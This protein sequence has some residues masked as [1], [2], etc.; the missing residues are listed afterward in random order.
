[1]GSRDRPRAPRAARPLG[2]LSCGAF[3]PDGRLAAL[4]S[5]NGTIHVVETA[6]GAELGKFAAGSRLNSLDFSADGRRLASGGDDGLALIWDTAELSKKSMLAG[7]E[8]KPEQLAV[9]WRD[10]DSPEAAKAHA[11]GRALA[12]SPR[13][14][15]PFLRA[16][17]Q[18]GETPDTRRIQRLI[19]QLDAEDFEE[20][21]KA[22]KELAAMNSVAVPLLRQALRGKP[23]AEVQD[24][25]MRLLEPYRD[26]GAA[27]ELLRLGRA[28]EAL[29]HSGTLDAVK[30]VKMLADADPQAPLTQQAKAAL[31]RLARRTAA[32]KND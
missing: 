9:L 26:Q 25:V 16:R 3:S 11:A 15:V 13:Q 12:A 10:L 22:H 17:L 5:Q 8:L 21:E 14:S 7:A 27:T 31:A 32:E 4:G 19:M 28:L 29:E 24:R 2:Q 30:V 18:A 6:T 20:R 23:S 1:M